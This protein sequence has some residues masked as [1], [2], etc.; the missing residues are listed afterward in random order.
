MRSFATSKI[1]YNVS[2]TPKE[3]GYLFPALVHRY[4]EAKELIQQLK[5]QHQ[6]GV[7]L[8]K[9]LQEALSTY[10]SKGATAYPN[11]R[12]AVDNYIHFERMHVYKEEE[13]LLHWH[14]NI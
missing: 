1:S 12:D 2:I 9:A 8:T 7:E 6:H 4:P 10:D 5:D 3:D 11:F 14:V 13:E